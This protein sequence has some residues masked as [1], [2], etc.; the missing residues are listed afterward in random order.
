MTREEHL[1]GVLALKAKAQAAYDD[2]RLVEAMLFSSHAAELILE[3]PE[4][5]PQRV[6]HTRLKADCERLISAVKQMGMMQ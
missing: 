6:D 4:F 3:H 1:D 5:W 2:D